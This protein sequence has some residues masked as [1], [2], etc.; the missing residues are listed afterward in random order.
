MDAERKCHVQE[1]LA[2]NKV[3]LSCLPNFS[4]VIADQYLFIFIKLEEDNICLVY[5]PPFGRTH[6]FVLTSL[7]MVKLVLS[8]H[9]QVC[10]YYVILTSLTTRKTRSFSILESLKRY[11]RKNSNVPFSSYNPLSPKKYKTIQKGWISDPFNEPNK[12][13][14]RSFC[15]IISQIQKD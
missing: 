9:G 5:N 11:V 10:R 7:A 2:T 14:A 4:L 3:S 12:T 1:W 13:S 8:C 6:R 15:V